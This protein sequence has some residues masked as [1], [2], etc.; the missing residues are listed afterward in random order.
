MPPEAA[1]V[2]NLAR[3][4]YVRLLCGSLEDLPAALAE[5]DAARRGA[6]PSAT[7]DHAADAIDGALAELR[8]DGTLAEISEKYFGADVTEYPWT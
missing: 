1:L 3:P 5:L 7:H 4:D 2:P 6:S 8:E